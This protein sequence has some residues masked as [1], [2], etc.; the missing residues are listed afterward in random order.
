MRVDSIK[1]A[2]WRNFKKEQLFPAPGINLVVGKNGQGKTNLLESVYF[3]STGFSPRINKKEELINHKNDYLY[4]SAKA[5]LSNSESVLVEMGLHRDSRRVNKLNGSPVNRLGEIAGQIRSVL[6]VPEDMDMVKGGPARRR[7]FMDLEICQLDG[8]YRHSLERYRRVLQQRN[9]LLKFSVVDKTL[10]AVLS[11]KM[12][13]LGLEISYKRRDFVKKLNLLARLRHRRLSDGTE[14]LALCYAPS[15]CLEEGEKGVE[16][17]VCEKA[18][19][20]KIQRT[21]LV[22]PHRDDMIF[23]LA[24][25][26]LRSY[27]SQGQQRTAVLAIKLAEVELFFAQT[28]E[29]PVLLLDDVFS[30]L[31]QARRRLLMECLPRG[32]QAIITATE[33]LPEISPQKTFSVKAGQIKDF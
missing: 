26:E 2:G 28:G 23:L 17:Q 5:T 11:E 3:L 16:E 29:L 1:L 18:K 20:E 9:A 7:R 10:L 33:P 4:V 25:E 24:K 19:Q 30:E 32:I 15:F 12:I 14:E 27:G 22:G 13:K 31:D 6:F 21:T 8:S